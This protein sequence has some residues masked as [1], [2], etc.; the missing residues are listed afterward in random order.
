MSERFL[1]ALPARAAPAVTAVAGLQQSLNF[2]VTFEA[3]D[4]PKGLPK[5][6]FIAAIK[7]AGPAGQ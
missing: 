2:A 1:S 3:V 5:A 7:K 6:K 4:A